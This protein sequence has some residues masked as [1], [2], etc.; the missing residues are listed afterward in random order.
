MHEMCAKAVGVG[1]SCH[2]MASLPVVC[3]LLVGE[4]GGGQ[5]EGDMDVI[6]ISLHTY[7]A[8]RK[9]QEGGTKW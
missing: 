3:R 1:V 9:Q 5:G 2:L 8:E 6:H 4:V 7:T